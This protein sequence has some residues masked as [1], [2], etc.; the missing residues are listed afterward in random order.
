[1]DFL[2]NINIIFTV[3][4]TLLSGF[5]SYYIGAKKNKADA[6]KT[7]METYNLAFESLRN[8]FLLKIERLEKEIE[9]LVEKKC[10]RKNCENRIS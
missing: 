4:L 8:E 5:S 1:M 6:Y 10:H 7:I 9:R 3:I 2:E